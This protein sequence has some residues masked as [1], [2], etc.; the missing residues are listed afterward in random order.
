MP[1]AQAIDCMIQA[2]RGLEAAHAE[3]IVHRDIKPGNLMLDAAGTVRVLDL[4]LARLVDAANPFGKAA[5]ARL[6]ESGM[7]MGTIDF[8][9]PEQAED[10]HRVDHRADIYSLGCTLFYLL[11]GR[12]CRSTAPPS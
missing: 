12:E 11:N 9:A 1:V 8:M 7:Y 3:G 4:G 5:G 6:T 2:A 10:S